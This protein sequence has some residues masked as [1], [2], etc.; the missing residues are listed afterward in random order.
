MSRETKA[1]AFCGNLFERDLRCTWAY[2]ER[3]KYCSQKC[4]GLAHS[5]EARLKRKPRQE[6]FERWIDKS[7]EC[8]LWLG[9]IDRDGYGIFTYCG[10]TY[11]AP[12]VALQLDGR[13]VPARHYAC[14]HCDNPACVRPS[15]LYVG[16]PTENMADAK[17]RGRVRVGERHYLSRLTEE[18][19]RK[20]RSAPGT[21]EAIAA[22]FGV[23]R[24]LISQIR[25]R[26][27]WAHVP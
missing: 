14:H 8:W 25:S 24:G 13:P 12:R 21:Q 27:I 4:A 17:K 10:A 20:I 22:R 18:D 26:K 2:W 16:T 6:V 9:A 1:C 15:H 5:A 7:G 23:T 11:R 3:A 19:V